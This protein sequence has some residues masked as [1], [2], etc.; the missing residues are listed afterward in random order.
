MFETFPG[1]QSQCVMEP[2]KE[3]RPLI[4]SV[5]PQL[6]GEGCSSGSWTARQQDPSFISHSLCKLEKVSCLF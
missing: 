2:S 3:A 5:V 6:W 1:L 4:A